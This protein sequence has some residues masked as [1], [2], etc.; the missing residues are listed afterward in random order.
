MPGSTTKVGTLDATVFTEGC[1]DGCDTWYQLDA[2]YNLS[3]TGPL[4]QQVLATFTDSGARRALM[5]GPVADTT[6]WH[7]IRFDGVAVHVPASW[8]RTALTTATNVINPGMCFGPKFRR[9]IH[10]TAYTGESRFVPSCPPPSRYELEPGNGLWLRAGADSSSPVLATGH[11]D[12]GLKIEAVGP[13]TDPQPDPALDVVVHTGTTKV[14]ISIG[15][16]LDASTA[17]AILGS[18]RRA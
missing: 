7:T 13:A 18:I 3:I 14:T 12:D 2:G 1:G 16:G 4:S 11:T 8:D 15:V 10:P 5:T 17:R 6:G 9:G